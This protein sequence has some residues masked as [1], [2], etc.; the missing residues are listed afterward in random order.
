MKD[1]KVFFMGPARFNITL[2]T[3]AVM[4]PAAKKTFSWSNVTLAVSNNYWNPWNYM[5]YSPSKRSLVDIHVICE[6][7]CN[8]NVRLNVNFP[9]GTPIPLHRHK[10]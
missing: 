10:P 9:P 3:G 2:F 1:C 5:E 7:G 4:A 6:M 8:L